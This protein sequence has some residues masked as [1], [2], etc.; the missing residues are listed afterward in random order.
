MI[1]IDDL[2]GGNATVNL[3]PIYSHLNVLDYNTSILSSRIDTLTMTAGGFD[4]TEQFSARS[5]LGLGYNI[6]DTVSRVSLSDVLKFNF[7]PNCTFDSCTFTNI[8]SLTINDIVAACSFDS[9]NN[10]KFNNDVIS[11]SFKPGSII[12]IGGVKNVLFNSFESVSLANIIGNE[13]WGNS[14]DN[15]LNWNIKC[16]DY[17]SNIINAGNLLN[18]TAT[19]AVSFSAANIDTIN[20]NCY[21]LSGGSLNN[22][23]FIYAQGH[24]SNCLYQLDERVKID[25]GNMESNT[26]SEC[27]NV[28]V[29]CESLFRCLINNVSTF[30]AMCESIETCTFN[31]I[32]QMSLNV[33][34]MRDNTFNTMYDA[35]ITGSLISKMIVTKMYS[36]CD[37]S[38]FSIDWLQINWDPWA[39]TYLTTGTVNVKAAFVQGNIVGAEEARITCDSVKAIGVKNCKKAT[40]SAKSIASGFWVNDVDDLDLWLD[41]IDLPSADADIYGLSNIGTLHIHQHSSYNGSGWNYLNNRP[42]AAFSNGVK[43]LDFDFKVPTYLINNGATTW[44]GAGYGYPGYHI[45]DIYVNGV[46]YTC[47]SH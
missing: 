10:A 44:N 42:M 29:S 45:S 12:N 28:G 27:T 33:Y 47:Y 40:I 14:I 11:C 22:E 21:A 25:G 37:I 13:V 6:S 18:I 19:S 35:H 36:L 16:D 31:D 41:N 3:N 32:K 17:Y 38:A 34:S 20:L 39:S 4:Y 5:S 23:S 24:M 15:A 43:C 26:F 7:G 2:S 8:S 46:A 1:S 30:H 9:W